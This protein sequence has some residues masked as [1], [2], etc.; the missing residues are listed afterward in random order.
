MTN[1]DTGMGR[2]AQK[3]LAFVTDRYIREGKDSTIKEIAEGLEWSE[4]AVRRVFREHD[5]LIDGMT[6]SESS[7]QRRE[8]NYGTVVGFKKVRVYGPSRKHLVSVIVGL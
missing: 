5:G 6:S 1:N 4:T 8:S 7:V 3:V 2:N